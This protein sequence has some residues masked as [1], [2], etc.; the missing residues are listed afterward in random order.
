LDKE[1]I[2]EMSNISTHYLGLELTGPVIAGSSNFTSNVKSIV[3]A[4]SAGAAAVVLKSLFEEQILAQS[5]ES[6][7]RVVIRK[8]AITLHG[9]P[10]ITPLTTTST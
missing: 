8:P 1:N 2:L 6:A 3:E 5:Y 9:I 7:R 10:E 4:E